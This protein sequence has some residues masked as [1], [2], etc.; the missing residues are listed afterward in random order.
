MA[1]Y[2]K[3]YAILCGVIDDVLDDLNKI[4]FALPSAAKLQKALLDAEEEY[5]KEEEPA[6]LVFPESKNSLE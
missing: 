2:K 6:V 1:N 5:V 3:M 4:P